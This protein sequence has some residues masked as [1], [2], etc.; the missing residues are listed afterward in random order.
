M[1]Q[2][3][4]RKVLCIICAVSG[5]LI[6]LAIGFHMRLEARLDLVTTYVAAKDIVPRT[7]I[8]EADILSMQVPRS[9]LLDYTYQTKEEIIGKYT[10]IQG[11]IPAGSPFYKSMLYSEEEIPDYPSTLLNK[12]QAAYSMEVDITKL[13]GNVVSGQRVDIHFSIQNTDGTV[14]SG[15]LIENA[16]IL[17]IQ[18]HRGLDI[19]DEN[20]S[21]TPYL[22]ILAVEEE[23]ISLLA[24][25]ES[26]GE[27]RL[28]TSSKTYDS[29]LEAVLV[30]D[31][32]A[33]NYLTQR[34][35]TSM[36]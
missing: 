4:F 22:A 34:Q 5:I 11:A 17:S 29:D 8:T 13:G 25:A 36:T 21:G 27:L 24:L 28:I 33:L 2:S 23:D 31:S 14:V 30:E 3:I 18:D 32:P 1:K 10:E 20:S 6:V 19:Q 16:R 12:G 26:L 7:K 15:I 35:D 9:Y